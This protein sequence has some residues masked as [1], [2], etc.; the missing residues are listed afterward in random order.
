LNQLP[1]GEEALTI[2]RQEQ[3]PLHN[4]VMLAVCYVTQHLF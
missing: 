3:A 1:D 2:L 4:W